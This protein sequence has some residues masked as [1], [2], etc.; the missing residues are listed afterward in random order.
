MIVSL[1]RYLSF[2]SISLNFIQSGLRWIERIACA[3]FQWEWIFLIIRNILSC[4]P[5]GVCSYFPR[6]SIVSKCIL[7]S[8]MCPITLVSINKSE[9]TFSIFLWEHEQHSLKSKALF[10]YSVTLP[11]PT[12]LHVHSELHTEMQWQGRTALFGLVRHK[13]SGNN[14]ISNQLWTESSGS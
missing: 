11:C 9:I 8:E 5:H 6:I 7:Y 10:L 2:H 13:W 12:D 4:I 14:A 3:L 1:F